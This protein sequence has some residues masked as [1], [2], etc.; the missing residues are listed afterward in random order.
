MSD[1]AELV[2]R[3]M[4]AWWGRLGLPLRVAIPV[5]LGLLSLGGAGYVIGDVRTDVARHDV[6]IHALERTMAGHV[7]AEAERGKAAIDVEHKVDRHGVKIDALHAVQ[8]TQ[9]GKLDILIR[10]L[11]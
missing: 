10:R 9:S 1:D 8:A 2:A 7:A 3:G 4:R 6:E 5:A 11:P